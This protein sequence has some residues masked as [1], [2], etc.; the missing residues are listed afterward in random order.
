VQWSAKITRKNWSRIERQVR[1]ISGLT[2]AC[3][4]IPHLI[5]HA[6][7]LI[8]VEA[9]EAM[10][11]VLAAFWQWLPIWW[12]LPTSL[13]T[14]L[15]FSIIA[16]FRR[17]T[18]QMP[19][20]EMI[21]LLLG[22]TVP[23]LL[24]GHIVGTRVT[25]TMTGMVT[26]YEYVLGTI[27]SSNARIVMQSVLVV[28]VW[29]HLCIGLHMWLRQWR[30]YRHAKSVLY[31]FAVLLPTLSLLG[32]WRGLAGVINTMD[33]PVARERIFIDWFALDDK[34]RTIL[35]SLENTLITIFLVGVSA[36]LVLRWGLIWRNRAS[37]VIRHSSGRVIPISRGQSML[38]AIRVAGID[39]ACIC[40]GNARCTTCRVEVSDGAEY[41]PEPSAMEVAALKRIST[42]RNIRLACQCYPVDD[43][44]ITPL[45]DPES[46]RTGKRSQRGG[47]AGSEQDVVAL[48]VDLR[49][50]TRLAEDKLPYD[51]VFIL[52][53][54]FSEMSEALDDTGGLYAQFTGDGLLALYGLDC[55]LEQAAEAALEGAHNMIER[56]EKLNSELGRE[57]T[58]PLTIGIGIHTGEA[59]V[60]DMGP[61]ATPIRSAIG[62]NINIAARL[63]SLT[64]EF[65]CQLVVSQKTIDIADADFSH[66]RLETATIE[67]RSDSL[68]VYVYPDNL[69]L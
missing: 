6:L 18:L 43:I 11:E 19:L 13:L 63:E 59:I 50:S 47:V 25:T 7:G 45:V 26:D 36:S 10:R 67:G 46:M 65:G 9:M 64:K 20:S 58:R 30:W 32:F 57:L 5:N 23:L 44:S 53:R 51:V 60:G 49:E 52:N 69:P 33:D 28:V 48:F 62:D 15:L 39:H 27:A 35:Y 16:V 17:T 31:A 3:Y 66:Y 55:P 37:A 24:L 61:P 12:I 41:L 8:S 1:L 14:H 4:L 68:L 56:V 29:V 21:Q 40:G 54:F 34:S 42:S 22:L 38:E 2:I